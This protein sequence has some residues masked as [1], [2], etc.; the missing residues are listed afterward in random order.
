MVVSALKEKLEVCYDVIVNTCNAV[1]LLHHVVDAV[2]GKKY[3]VVHNYGHS[4]HGKHII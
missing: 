2:S 1:T 3:T 4:S